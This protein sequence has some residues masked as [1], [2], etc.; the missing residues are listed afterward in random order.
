MK[1]ILLLSHGKFLNSDLPKILGRSLL[2]W[3]VLHI[4]TAANGARV[5]MKPYWDTVHEALEKYGCEV[6]DLDLE[7]KTKNELRDILKN[8][9]AVFINGGN[10]FYLLKEMRASGF[11]E[12]LKEL[13]PQGLV[14]MGASAGAYVM[15][16][17]IE[18]S[19]WDTTRNTFGLTD[20]SALNFAPFLL[21]AHYH[22]GK[23]A[24]IKEKSQQSKYPI[25]ILTDE[26]AILLKDNQMEF[27][28]GPEIVL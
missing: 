24:L 4:T 15:C 22:P 19:G 9:E 6:K 11:S 26:Q 13:I 18:V 27:L 25:R 17:T 12:L 5:D 23:A 3:R 7:G 28:G 16:P 20:L 10:T 2:G 21:S 14:Y 1:T 8:F